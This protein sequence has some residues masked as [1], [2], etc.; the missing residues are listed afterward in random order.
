M[1][2]LMVDANVVLAKKWASGLGDGV[3]VDH[4]TDPWAAQGRWSAGHYDLVLVH[5]QT[6]SEPLA[7]KRQELLNDCPQPVAEW[8]LRTPMQWA[9]VSRI[10]DA[11]PLV[12]AALAAQVMA[13]EDEDETVKPLTPRDDD[14][15]ARV[16]AFAVS[17]CCWMAIGASLWVFFWHAVKG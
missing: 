15:G 10:G 17:A 2:I 14:E 5:L 9:N 1:K 16:A 12:A 3:E 4:V 7:Q 8:Q 6:M 13:E 11:A